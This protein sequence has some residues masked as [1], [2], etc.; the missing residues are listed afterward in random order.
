MASCSLNE[1]DPVRS[2]L[3]RVS[4]SALEREVTIAETQRALS[5]QTEDDPDDG[6]DTHRERLLRRRHARHPE[7]EIG[8]GGPRHPRGGGASPRSLEAANLPDELRKPR[9]SANSSRLSGPCPSTRPTA[10]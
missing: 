7:E 2:A 1:P 4:A 6:S 9:R 3:E 10:T 5:S 8:E